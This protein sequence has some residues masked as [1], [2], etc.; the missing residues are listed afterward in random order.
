MA[1]QSLKMEQTL[2]DNPQ[3][4]GKMCRV[5]YCQICNGWKRKAMLLDA[6]YNA[7][8]RSAFL[9][10]NRKGCIIRDVSVVDQ[11]QNACTCK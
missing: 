6:D 10:Y 8:D 7:D 3:N 11:P 2:F 1:L 4:Q 9:S 5:A